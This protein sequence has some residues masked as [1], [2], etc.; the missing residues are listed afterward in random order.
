MEYTLDQEIYQ[1]LCLLN[2][3]KKKSILQ[4]LKTFAVNDS[5]LSERIA[6]EQYNRELEDSEKQIEAGRFTTQE[7]LEKEMET[8]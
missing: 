3:D 5:Q 4:L 1:H 6:L 2:E 7:E 8:W